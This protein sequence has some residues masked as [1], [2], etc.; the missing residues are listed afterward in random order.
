VVDGTGRLVPDGVPGELWVGGAGLA[1]GYLARPDLT[2]Q[3][4]VPHPWSAVPGL[5][6]YRSGD[7][8]LRRDGELHY[9]GRIDQQVKIRGFRVEL[10]EI[11]AA[12][13]ALPAVREAVVLLREDAADDRRLAAYLTLRP[14]IEAPSVS[15]LRD[16]LAAA[17][18]DYMV[19][20][21]FVVLP[22]LPLTQNGK[23][24]RRALPAPGPERPDLAARFVEPAGDLESV[25]AGMWGEVLGLERVGAED[26]FFELGGNSLLAMRLF[27]RVEEAFQ[28]EVPLLT[29]YESPTVR[30]LARAL[31]AGERRPGETAKIARVLRRVRALSA[32][33]VSR[34]LAEK[35]KEGAP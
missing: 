16:S 21:A 15:A 20:A 34:L 12:L 17:L 33:G 30:G 6:L 27:G 29:L 4:F 10:G 9:L 26:D 14:G 1:R 19:P 11:E 2:A 35:R 24:D 7:L 18:P 28:R 25:L 5:R 31:T 3:R 8:V 22:A 32:Q 13:L 23:L